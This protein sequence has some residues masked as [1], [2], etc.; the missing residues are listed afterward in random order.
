MHQCDVKT[1]FT[2]HDNSQ[3]TVRWCTDTWVDLQH[4]CSY[5]RMCY[6]NMLKFDESGEKMTSKMMKNSANSSHLGCPNVMNISVLSAEN[7]FTI[8]TIRLLL[9]WCVFH[10]VLIVDV[11]FL[12]FS[13]D[14]DAV[15]SP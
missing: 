1:T 3:T 15:A 2:H 9:L 11:G 7:W 6:R 14:F 8:V 13:V 5:C 4:G 10:E 12:F